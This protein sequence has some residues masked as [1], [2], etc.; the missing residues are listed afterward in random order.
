MLCCWIKAI[1]EV[2]AYVYPGLVLLFGLLG[3]FLFAVTSVRLIRRYQRVRR[4]RKNQIIGIF[5]PYCNAGGG[6]ERVLWC[7]IKFL[8]LHHPH[9]DIVVYSGDLGVTSQDI[10]SKMKK[11]FQIDLKKAPEFVFLTSRTFVEASWYPVLTLLGQ[12][13]GSLILGT[14][15]L[16]RCV[17]D[18]FVDTMG[19]SFTYPLFRQLARCRVASYTHYPTIST[20]MLTAIASSSAN[21]N[22]R[23]VISRS[24]L[25][26]KAK[27]FYYQIFAMIYGLAGRQA[28]CI[29]VNSSWT[30]NHINSLWKVPN[31]TFLV[32][33]PCNTKAFESLE[34]ARPPEAKNVI[35]SVAQFR[36][37]K[38]HL[39]QL[40]ALQLLIQK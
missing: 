19:Y 2:G 40:Q 33:P 12:S 24:P 17:P 30:K 15:A 11:N 14:E 4:G 22:N 34:L 29:L 31:R 13:L 6:G 23:A 28:H 16:V 9:L 20:D 25:L 32:Y 36:P 8:E 3:A 5:H 10:M 18:Y 7:F 35:V 26:T 27:L 1:G 37:E 21:F 39:L 38:N